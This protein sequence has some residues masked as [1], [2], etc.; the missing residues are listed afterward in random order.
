[1]TQLFSLRFHCQSERHWLRE[2][3]DWYAKVESPLHINASA[4]ERLIIEAA[5]DRLRP[6]NI[7]SYPSI[8]PITSSKESQLPFSQTNL[9]ENPILLDDLIFRGIPLD[10]LYD[11][12]VVRITQKQ[13]VKFGLALSLTEGKVMQLV[14]KNTSIP[15][16]HVYENFSRKIGDGPEVVYLIMEYIEGS[17]LLD[18]WPK[19]E[20]SAKDAI[21]RTLG[22]YIKE[23]RT[24][25]REMVTE[26]V[27][28]RA[29]IS[30]EYDQICS[31][32]G[33]ALPGLSGPFAS[34]AA[35]HNWFTSQGNPDDTSRVYRKMFR[36]DYNVSFSHGDLATRNIMVNEQG[37]I[38]SILDW[39]W[40]GWYPEYIEFV[41]SVLDGRNG[42]W[43][44][45]VERATG[46]FYTEL[47]M[48]QFM[49]NRGWVE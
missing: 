26:D 28:Q 37:K 16:P 31:A 7:A 12:K 6:S 47:G 20:T 32:D 11:N 10:V 19:L 46:S 4:A 44:Q 34:V 48:Y 40:A 13:V 8:P 41:H 17:P 35:Y 29:L 25:T 22:V 42:D 18:N 3:Y 2:F 43:W 5:K 23:L 27:P 14:A 33:G 24:I 36:D 1:M 49:K 39:G 21:A 30:G 9:E 15:V 45:Y 38:V